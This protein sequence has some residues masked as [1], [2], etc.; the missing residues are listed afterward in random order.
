MTYVETG[1]GRPDAV[2]RGADDSCLV[3]MAAADEAA[4]Q[5]AGLPSPS[6]RIT[7]S[8]RRTWSQHKLRHEPMLVGVLDQSGVGL[9]GCNGG[10]GTG[11]HIPCQD[12]MGGL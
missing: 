8:R 12:M 6:I 3:D 9:E 5:S 1:R 7:M 11:D 4:L 10:G 2:A